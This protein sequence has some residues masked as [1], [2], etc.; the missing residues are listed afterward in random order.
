MTASWPLQPAFFC[1]R[2]HGDSANFFFDPRRP[3]WFFPA[4]HYWTS[5]GVLVAIGFSLVTF[6]TVYWST[7]AES[8]TT[9]SSSSKIFPLV[10]APSF[11]CS[12]I[13]LQ[14]KLILQ[15]QQYHTFPSHSNLKKSC[16][17]K[18]QQ[19]CFR[20]NT[21]PKFFPPPK[22]LSVLRDY[23]AYHERC[24]RGFNLTALA[25]EG[26]APENCKFLIWKSMDGM[27]NQLISLVSA[28]IYAL[29][30]NRAMLIAT[31]S[32][33]HQYLC[34]PFPLS[35]WLLPEG[36]READLHTKADRLFVYLDSIAQHENQSSCSVR[37]NLTNWIAKAPRHLQVYIVCCD[38]FRDNQ[39]FCPTVQKLLTG[40]NWMFYQSHEYTVPALYFVPEFRQLL[41]NWFPEKQ[42]FMH[43]A[44]YL[45]N[46]ENRLWLHITDLYRSHMDGADKKVGIQVRSW[47]GNYL[48]SVSKQILRCGLDEKLLQRPNQEDNSSQNT[49]TSVMVASLRAE[50]YHN[51][52]AE[53]SKKN[54]SSASVNVF[55]ASQEGSQKTGSK[56][57]DE[58]AITDIWLL[59]FSDD[60]VVTPISTFGTSA[61][62]LAGIIPLVFKNYEE[63]KVQE[64]ACERTNVAGPCFM[65]HPRYQPCDLDPPRSSIFDPG[66][67]LPEIQYCL[68]NRGF[69]IIPH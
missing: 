1:L 67:M 21:T 61:S 36:F 22:F 27:G 10:H 5:P 48:P 14:P 43:G 66:F 49:T 47:K 16:Q 45:L 12:D 28:F 30:T 54:S 62:G 34:N 6:L 2:N 52:A 8:D 53:F 41:N 26:R 7:L 24:T 3:F 4:K 33:I 29:L 38:A 19:H 64:A 60:L 69:S 37:N 15:E 46:P 11:N 32:H 40:V 59:S 57:H 18:Y 65:D 55:T 20:K 50:Y 31:D 25:I 13:G 44:R 63:D 51:L 68:L 42:V 56:D 35:S 9:L 17:S 39:F 23:E 58:K